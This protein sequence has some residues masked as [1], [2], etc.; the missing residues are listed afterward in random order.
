ML[1]VQVLRGGDQDG[2]DVLIVQQ[3]AIVQVGLGVG[4]DLLDVFQAAGVDVG[5]A[6]A[7]DVGAGERLAKDLA[8]RGRRAR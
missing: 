5:G 7:F 2:I 8:S 3:A 1:A 4:R 6:D